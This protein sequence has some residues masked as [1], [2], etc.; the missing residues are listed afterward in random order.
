MSILS[1]PS[2]IQSISLLSTTNKDLATNEEERVKALIK[3]FEDRHSNQTVQFISRAPGRVNLIG[4]HIDYMDYGVL[5]IAIEKDVLIATSVVDSC[6]TSNSLFPTFELFIEN[7]NDKQYQKCY[8]N[9]DQMNRCC[10]QNLKNYFSNNNNNDTTVNQQ[11]LFGRLND[12]TKLQWY[13]FILCGFCAI[14]DNLSTDKNRI[15]T[16]LNLTRNKHFKIYLL[17]DGTVPSGSGLSS[18]SA[19]VCSSSVCCLK[20]FQLENLFTKHELAKYTAQSERL[21]GLQSGGMDQAISFLGKEN[22]AQYIQFKPFIQN[23]NVKLPEGV[24]FVVSHSLVSSVKAET[25]AFNYNRR[26]AECRLG[27]AILYLKILKKELNT[28]LTLYNLQQD[29]GKSLLELEKLVESYL[30]K[31]SYNLNEIL[32][33]ELTYFKDE[34]ELRDVLLKNIKLVNENDL[35]LKQRCLHVFSEARRVIEFEE[36]CRKFD[37][38]EEENLSNE[39]VICQL[40]KLMNESHFS[41]RDLYECS[42]PELEILTEICR[43][44]NGCL[45]S[46]L[47]GAGWGGCSVSLVRDENL[48]EFLENVYFKYYEQRKDNFKERKDVLFPTKPCEGAN[49][50]LN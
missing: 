14:F 29:M 23:T 28:P 36:I 13:H 41:C 6:Q 46:R 1:E 33:E 16:F 50:Y 22:A 18:S 38:K 37:S 8:L 24:T 9:S 43:S 27:C 44:S 49:I 42:S 39:T 32:K 25:A 45:G 26:V 30:T 19:L 21:I 5:P 20:A 10:L 40:G 47:T 4:E 35:K 15:E 17:V 34:Q 2:L 3:C 7:V 12:E 11:S 48:N 31:D